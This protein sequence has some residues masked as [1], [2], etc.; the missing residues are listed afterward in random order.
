[1]QQIRRLGRELIVWIVWLAALCR[2]ISNT[3]VLEFGSSQ[4]FLGSSNLVL[5]F[6]LNAF[7]L[8]QRQ[9]MDKLLAR[10]LATN[11]NSNNY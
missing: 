5:Q 4:D 11:F 2:F 3:Y 1:M 10:D 8:F 6:M 7:L 9:I